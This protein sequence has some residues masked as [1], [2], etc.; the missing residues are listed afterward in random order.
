MEHAMYK[1]EVLHIAKRKDIQNEIVRAV[2]V[3]RKAIE[4]VL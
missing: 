2:N 3:H 4:L 1:Y